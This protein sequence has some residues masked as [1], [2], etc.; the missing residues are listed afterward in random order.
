MV[1]IGVTSR[2]SGI[3]LALEAVRY[4]A[5]YFNHRSEVLSDLYKKLWLLGKSVDDTTLV[6]DIILELGVWG[7][8]IQ[9][10]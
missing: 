5:Y 7:R 8:T 9:H 4:K 3:C 10:V 2:Q 1:V 6:D